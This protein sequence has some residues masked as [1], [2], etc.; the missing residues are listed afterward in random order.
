MRETAERRQCSVPEAVHWCSVAPG[1]VTPQ[2][3]DRLPP[4]G[5]PVWLV[6]YLVT[7]LMGNIVNW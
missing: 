7:W 3:S 6:T 5:V 4:G 1:D 2:T